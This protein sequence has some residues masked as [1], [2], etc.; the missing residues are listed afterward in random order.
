MLEALDIAV[1][2]PGDEM[3]VAVKNAKKSKPGVQR[4]YLGGNRRRM[5]ID[6]VIGIRDNTYRYG[7]RFKTVHSIP[8]KESAFRT[9]MD[10]DDVEYD[11][12]KRS[13]YRGFPHCVSIPRT[14]EYKPYAAVAIYVLSRRVGTD[15]S[16]GCPLK[17]D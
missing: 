13:S 10:E 8:C 3:M 15:F 2:I 17:G 14:E 9:D 1:V 16:V 7:I 5:S 6:F 4:L 11:K 12:K